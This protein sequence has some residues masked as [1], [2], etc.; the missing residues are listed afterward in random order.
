MSLRDK[1]NLSTPN[2]GRVLETL[3]YIFA[4]LRTVNSKTDN[5]VH[6]LTTYYRMVL[7]IPMCDSLLH[8]NCLSINR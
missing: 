7:D 2:Q 3:I 8:L 1:W 4:R 5:K 6:L